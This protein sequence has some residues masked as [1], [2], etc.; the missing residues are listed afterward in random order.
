MT[1]RQILLVASTTGYQ[2]H[3]FAEAASR[4]GVPVQ[5]IDDTLNDAFAQRQIATVYTPRNQYRIVIEI[6]P[7]LQ[8]SPRDL[9]QVYVPSI[10]GTQ[11]PLSALSKVETRTSALVV[12]HQGQFPSVT[13]S[14]NLGPGA[15]LGQAVSAIHEAEADIGMPPS[16]RADFTG[17]AQ[18]FKR[19]FP[20]P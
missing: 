18:A 2:L 11:V 10:T 9:D 13:I 12:N 3:S 7:K 5:A 17:T 6:D 15:S 8:K 4:L 19:Y 1:N 14:L 16:V 20:G